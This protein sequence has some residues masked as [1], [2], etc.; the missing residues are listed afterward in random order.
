M[1]QNQHRKQEDEHRPEDDVLEEGTT[2]AEQAEEQETSD[3]DPLAALLIPL[4]LLATA[5]VIGLLL[6]RHNAMRLETL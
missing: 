1:T 5:A 2:E 6:A 4:T 3:V